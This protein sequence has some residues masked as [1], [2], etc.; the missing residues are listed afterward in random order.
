MS[1]HYPQPRV[2]PVNRRFLEAWR[3]EGSLLVQRCD[4]CQ[5]VY[6]Y[7]RPF[8]TLCFSDNVGWLTTSGLGTVLSFTHVHRPNH[9][10]FFDEVPIVLAEVSLPEG[11]SLL[12]R[13]VGDN[14]TDIAEGATLALVTG[15]E[16][17]RYP[18]PTFILT[19]KAP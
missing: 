17:S 11:P 8:C 6:F 12:A 19:E 3:D 9:P 15:E 13:V 2:T 18:L 5:H 16:R 4:D 1:A 7:P 14:R 10:S